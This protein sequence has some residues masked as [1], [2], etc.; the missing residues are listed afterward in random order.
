M[1]TITFWSLCCRQVLYYAV[2]IQDGYTLDHSKD[3]AFIT[4]FT[5]FQS[6]RTLLPILIFSWSLRKVRPPWRATHLLSRV[7]V[8]LTHV[9]LCVAGHSG[10]N[11]SEE[12][13]THVT[14]PWP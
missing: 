2:T 11:R 3:Y 1:V 4:I 8:V 5:V 10:S 7:L 12:E 13:P 6:L 14:G 9:L